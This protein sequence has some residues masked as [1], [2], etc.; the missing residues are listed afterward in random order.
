MTDLSLPGRASPDRRRVTDER[1]PVD[2]DGHVVDEQA[3]R[4]FLVARQL[5]HV[6]PD[7]AQRV[8]ERLVFL[9]RPVDVDPLAAQQVVRRRFGERVGDAR[10]QREIVLETA[11][12]V[13]HDTTLLRE[14][15]GH[16]RS[17]AHNLQLSIQS[18]LSAT[19]PPAISAINW[20]DR[21]AEWLVRAPA[22]PR[23]QQASPAI[24]RLGWAQRMMLIG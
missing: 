4:V 14:I 6:E 1:G 21:L 17:S 8:D 2:H 7:S 15:R 23:A 9:S 24:R 3:V 11:R 20:T 19:I 10:D 13:R 16:F 18:L 5:D 12:R 22:P